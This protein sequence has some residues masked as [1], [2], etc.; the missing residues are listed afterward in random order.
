MVARNY[1]SQAKDE[2]GEFVQKAGKTFLTL[3][4]ADVFGDC[5]RVTVTLDNLVEFFATQANNLTSG[6]RTLAGLTGDWRPIS[7]L[8]NACLDWFKH[9]NVQ[10]LRRAARRRN[11]TPRF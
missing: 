6:C 10:G 4:C 3:D 5:Q 2:L 1:T 11:L 9:V 7:Q 8:A